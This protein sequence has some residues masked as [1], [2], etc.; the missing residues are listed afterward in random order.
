MIG[1]WFATIA[2]VGV[3][4]YSG[5]SKL[6]GGSPLI[7]RF[8]YWGYPA[9]FL[10]VVGAAEVVGAA[11]LILPK[12]ALYGAIVLGAVMAGAV[13]THVRYAEWF[14]ALFVV[15]VLFL[16]SMVGGSRRSRS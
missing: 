12:T 11:L 13:F 15:I 5:I 10:L 7:D 3:F 8:T 2:L 9:W 4:A 1:V 14:P 16:L 6:I